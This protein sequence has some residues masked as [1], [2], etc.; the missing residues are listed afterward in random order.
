MYYALDRGRAGHRTGRRWFAAPW[1]KWQSFSSKFL[2]SSVVKVLTSLLG[3]TLLCIVVCACLNVV[4]HVAMKITADLVSR[5]G[6]FLNAL[7]E[8]ELDLRGYKIP[9]IEN[10]GA[11]QVGVAHGLL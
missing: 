5:A 2:R 7:K 1:T 3:R 11:S 10:L 4:Q 9:A 6:Q 8:R